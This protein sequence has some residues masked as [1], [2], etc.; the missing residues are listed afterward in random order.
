MLERI[1]QAGA[2][3]FLRKRYPELEEAEGI[4]LNAA[5]TS[6]RGVAVEVRQQRQDEDWA[7]LLEGHIG[8]SLQDA[9]RGFLDAPSPEPR[10]LPETDERIKRFLK[11][12][13]L[14]SGIL[15]KTP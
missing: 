7:E 8:V 3:A 14:V 12:G 15:S 6:S 4:W 5:E 9:L 2:L 1:L 11:Y 13:R 10:W